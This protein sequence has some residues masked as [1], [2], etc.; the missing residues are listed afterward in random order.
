M[1]LKQSTATT[2][3]L[4]P[5]V[6]ESDAKTAET[7]L[8][9]SQADVRLSKNGGAFAQKSDSGT[10]S[11]LENGHYACGLNATDTNTLGRLRVAVHEAGALPVWLDLEVV[12]A[13]V[14]DSLFGADRLQVHADEITAGLITAAAIAGGAIDAD[15]VAADVVAEIADAVWDEALGSHLAAGSAGDTLSDAAA[16][17]ASPAAIADAVWDEALGDHLAA[18]SAG[19]ALNDAGGAAADPWA[20]TLPGGYSSNTAGWLLGTRLDARISSVSGNSPG[21]G[22]AE[23][24]YTLTEEG[25]GNPIADA[26]VWATSDA[27]GGNILASGRTDQNGQIAFYLDPGTVYLWRQKSGWNFVNPDVETVA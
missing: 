23:F 11:H 22:A 9:L 24:T 18:G 3:I 2:L 1:Y 15:A 26:D 16:G 13:N 7:G 20:T 21:A 10:C 12:P 4:G 14:W 25:T 8:T 19:D 6:D 27:N 5:F 17:S